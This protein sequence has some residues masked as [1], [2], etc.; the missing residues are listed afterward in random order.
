MADL[1]GANLVGT[2]LSQANLSRADLSGA[3]LSG[4]DLSG[5]SLHGANLIGANLTGANL[6]GTDLRTAYLEGVNFSQV[7]LATT[8][9][10]GAIGIP[11]NAA[12]PQQFYAWGYFAAEKYDYLAAIQ[13]Y[14]QS[15]TLDPDFA[16]A[17][18]GRGVAYLN[19]R[20]LISAR[21]DLMVAREIFQ[22]EQYPEGQV[23]SQSFID[24][25]DAT[26]AP[27]AKKGGGF[28][29]ILNQVG[30]MLFQ[31]LMN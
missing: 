11:A 1:S 29:R 19:Q 26:L 28:G 8:Y 6:T 3:N 14:N 16:P 5:A 25:I 17:Y 2:N 7:N 9:I 13:Y 27:Q 22:E 24:T 15:L 12:S 23:I 18:L 31:F 4:A 10:D 20:D 21:E 30:S